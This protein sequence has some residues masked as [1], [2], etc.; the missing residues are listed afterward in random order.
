MLLCINI[1]SKTCEKE[2]RIMSKKE[3]PQNVKGEVDHIWHSEVRGHELDIQKIVNNAHYLQYFDHARINLLHSLGVDWEAWH[4]NGYNLVLA[5][6]DMSLKAPLRAND[7]F[8]ISSSISR[9]GKLKI[10]FKQAIFRKP[11]EKLI[12]EATNTVVCVSIKNSR[13]TLPVELEALLFS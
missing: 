2:R 1:S 3:L 10:L 7:Q 12:A 13:P 5:H 9:V 11:D 6:V 4:K 8:Y